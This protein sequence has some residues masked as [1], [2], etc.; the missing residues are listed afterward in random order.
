MLKKFWDVFVI[1]ED[2]EWV[3]FRTPRFRLERLGV[4]FGLV[5][6]LAMVSA[7]GWVLSRAQSER[8]H[9]LWTS[10]KLRVQSLELQVQSRVD[11]LEPVTGTRRGLE[12]AAAVSSILPSLEGAAGV[13]DR[14]DVPTVEVSYVAPSK[15]L[16]LKFE[17]VRADAS[18]VSD[19]YTWIL[20]LSA[21]PG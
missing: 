11:S 6:I 4:L 9:R 19:K 5:L 2:G 8:L 21:P 16:Q 17:I 7:L 13:A 10:E 14:V 12:G 3:A 1:R 20:V 15:E 18:E